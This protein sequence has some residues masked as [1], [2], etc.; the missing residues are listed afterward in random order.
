MRYDLEDAVKTL[1]DQLRQ[2]AEPISKE[3][4][5]ARATTAAQIDNETLQEQVTHLQSKISILEDQ[6]HEARAAADTHE[7][8]YSA[9]M[10]RFRENELQLKKDLETISVERNAVT[11]S[12][13]A[14]L[15]R[16]QEITVALQESDAALEDARA[17]IEALR[18]D[19]AVS[20]RALIRVDL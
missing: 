9:R 17:E 19:L 2:Q 3:E 12:E 1:Q 6:L 5:A 14:A 15:T 20:D 4:L 16:V 18:S 11:T 13:V 7:Q 10:A 8:A